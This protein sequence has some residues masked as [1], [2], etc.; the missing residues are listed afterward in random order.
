MFW[1]RFLGLFGEDEAAKLLKKRGYRI[2]QRNYS[3]RYGEIDIIAKDGK[4]LVFIE[5]KTLSRGK[6]ETPFDTITERKRR[7]I[8]NCAEYYL[9]YKKLKD[10]PIRFDAVAV[11]YEGKDQTKIEIVKGAF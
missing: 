4:T 11:W 6:A 1:K 5:V 7:H 3:C 2:I 9:N 10:T 8:E